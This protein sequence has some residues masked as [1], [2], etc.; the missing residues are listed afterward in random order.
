MNW[1]QKR[2]ERERSNGSDKERGVHS[3]SLC[4]DVCPRVGKQI[5]I[6]ARIVYQQDKVLLRVTSFPCP[7]VLESNNCYCQAIPRSICQNKRV[8]C[9]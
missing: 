9:C 8:N 4:L 5:T 3:Q 7:D 1:W 2:W 6:K